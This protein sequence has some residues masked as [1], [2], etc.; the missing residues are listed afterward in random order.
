VLEATLAD[1]ERTILAG[2]S[3][4]GMTIVAWAGRHPDEVGR[5]AAAVALIS[6]GMG[7]L[8]S[9]SLVV[10]TPERFK[11]GG[12]RITQLLLS[13]PLPVPRSPAP[14]V[15]RA[16]RFVALSRA[17][18]PAQVDFTERMTIDARRDVRA[19][20]AATLSRLDLNRSVASVTVP[21]L[22]M[23]GENDRLPPPPPHARRLEEALPEPAELV[24]IPR[25]GHMLPLEA[26]DDVTGGLRGLVERHLLSSSSPVT[27]SAAST[28]GDPS[29]SSASRTSA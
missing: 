1:G 16:V 22:V 11:S 6:P 7:D 3:I 17:A 24:E 23:V 25:F 15:H 28:G 18:G 5:R 9:E 8:I 29:P 26:P 19:A 13:S 14:L 10:R 4:G 12:E 20:S 27:A 21:A 2:H